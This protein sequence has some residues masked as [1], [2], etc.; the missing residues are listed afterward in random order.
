[1]MSVRSVEAIAPI[2]PT[3]LASQTVGNIGLYYVCYRF[4]RLGWNA[5]P[6]ARNA[7]GIDVLIYSQDGSRTITIQVKALSKRNPVP[8]GAK[9]DAL[10]ADFVVIVR[11]AKKDAPKSYVLTKDE[12]R[13]HVRRVTLKTGAKYNFIEPK[14]YDVD[15]YRE[16]W[17]RI[18]NGS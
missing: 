8:I 1:M 10:I 18:G 14:H 12:A 4:S 5:M 17:D 15:T 6:T 9:T 2:E 13:Q 3:K 16:R 7:R 11:D